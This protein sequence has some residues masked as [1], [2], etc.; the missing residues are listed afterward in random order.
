MQLTPQ[1]WLISLPRATGTG[2]PRVRHS[3]R[4]WTPQ[5]SSGCSA[6]ISWN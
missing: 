3:R 4:A 2:S 1:A 6:R 5:A